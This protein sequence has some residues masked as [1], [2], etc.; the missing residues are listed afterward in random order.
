MDKDFEIKLRKFLEEK[1]LYS[2]MNIELP[3]YGHQFCNLNR[4]EMQY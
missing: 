4:I 1:P 3:E 2:W